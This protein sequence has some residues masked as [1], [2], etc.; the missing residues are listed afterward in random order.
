MAASE[1]REALQM[2]RDALMENKDCEVNLRYYYSGENSPRV[3]DRD[4]WVNNMSV[5]IGDLSSVGDSFLVYQLP[6]R[7][8][9][10]PRVH[11]PNARNL[12]LVAASDSIIPY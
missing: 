8:E 6:M 3:P 4:P 12:K 11:Q 5:F 2:M 1:F 9:T 7:I 10:T